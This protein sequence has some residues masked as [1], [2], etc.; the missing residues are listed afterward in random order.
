MSYLESYLQTV[1]MPFRFVLNVFKSQVVYFRLSRVILLFEPQC[2]T[3]AQ[4]AYWSIASA[5]SE[6]DGI[7]YTDPEEV[8]AE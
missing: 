7:D 6:A 8:C 5:L 2:F 4:E 3:D 1:S